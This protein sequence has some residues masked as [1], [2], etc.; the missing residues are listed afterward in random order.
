MVLFLIFDVDF[1]LW[2][3]CM[4]LGIRE[5]LRVDE[6][7][8]EQSVFHFLLDESCSFSAIEPNVNISER[9]LV[10]ENVQYFSVFGALV[11]NV[12]PDLDIEIRRSFAELGKGRRI[13][14]L[15]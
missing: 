14:P 11:R 7:A 9:V 8:R 4:V 6:S 5:K 10:H 3:C 13:L 2:E 15:K 1:E 12:A